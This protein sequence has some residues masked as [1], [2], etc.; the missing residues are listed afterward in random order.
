MK[1]FR[2]FLLV[3]LPLFFLLAACQSQPATKTSSQSTTS[4]KKATT[5]T[6]KKVRNKVKLTAVPLIGTWKTSDGIQFTFNPDGKW[7]Y[8]TSNG[9]KTDGTFQVA[10]GY[11]R[12]VLLKLHGLDQGIGGIGNYL[13]VRFDT[14]HKKLNIVGFGHFTLAGEASHITTDLLMTKAFSGTPNTLREELVGTW[15]NTDEN[16]TDAI[17][18][19]YNPDGTYERYSSANKEVEEG[20]FAVVNNHSDTKK[21]EIKL[22]PSNSKAYTLN[23]TRDNGISQLTSSSKGVATTYVKNQMPE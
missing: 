22:S 15:M 10:G 1:Q 7:V 4:S 3:L 8:E 5:S 11:G 16:A 20:R 19:N 6:K 13:G 2:K 18:T 9:A 23:F 12:D 17:T 21:L 14:T